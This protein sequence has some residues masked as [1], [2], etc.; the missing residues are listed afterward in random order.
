MDGF[1]L[2]TDEDV[3][4]SRE[5]ILAEV[6]KL[7]Q[8][9][10]SCKDVKAWKRAGLCL[11][12]EEFAQSNYRDLPFVLVIETRDEKLVVMVKANNENGWE[13]IS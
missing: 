12:E 7:R 8:V 13:F 5:K 6:K 1:P 4:P 3:L 2:R 10:A 9:L 11:T